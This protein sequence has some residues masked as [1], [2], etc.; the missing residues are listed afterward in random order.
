MMDRISAYCTEVRNKYCWGAKDLLMADKHASIRI[1]K[2]NPPENKDHIQV[3]IL[4]PC[5]IC[6]IQ[7]PGSQFKLYSGTFTI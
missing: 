7:Q 6:M 5:F 3:N 1:D 4:E 2:E